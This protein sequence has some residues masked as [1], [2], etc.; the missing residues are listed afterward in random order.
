[1]TAANDGST[2]RHGETDTNPKTVEVA[3]LFVAIFITII[4]A[5]AILRAGTAGAL[6][7]LVAMVETDGQPHNLAYFWLTGL[8][9]RFLDNAPTY[10]VFF[11]IAGGDAQ[12]GPASSARRGGRLQPRSDLGVVAAKVEVGDAARVVV[13]DQDRGCRIGLL[14]RL[15]GQGDLRQGSAGHAAAV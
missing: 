1:M 6:G 7:G 2:A 11:N 3:K 9:S 13:E 14:H 8:L 5:I 15:H 12:L 10:L 4:P